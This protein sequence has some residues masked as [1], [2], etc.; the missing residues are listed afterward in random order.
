[1]KKPLPK[2]DEQREKR[3]GAV[4][5]FAGTPTSVDV[6]NRSFDIVV[7]TET[8]VRTWISDPRITG[9]D[10]DNVDC[11]SIEVD[12]VLVAAGLDMS[13]AFRMP[14]I[15]SHDTYSGIDKI[16]GKIDNL[17]VEGNQVVA[18]PTLTRARADLMPDIADGFYGQ[19]SAGYTPLVT[20]IVERE[21]QVPLAMV[22]KWVLTEASLVAVGADPNSFIRSA[23]PGPTPTV[24]YRA[25]PKTPTKETTMATKKTTNAA[26]KRADDG[27]A[28]GAPDIDAIVQQAEDAVAAAETAV[29]AVDDAVS[30]SSDVSDETMER[31][32][33]LRARL[34]AADD[35][36]MNGDDASGDNASG[37]TSDADAADQKAT[38][39]A[40]S[41][42]RSYGLTKL[43][44]DMVK[45]GARSDEVKRSLRTAI[46]AKTTTVTTPTA[47]ITQKE[48]AAGAKEEVS[49]FARQRTAFNKLNNANR[50]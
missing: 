7:T 2:P 39:E 27:T 8:P 38:D 31:A 47:S 19:I 43:V 26:R 34:R 5:A 33:G 41:I 23:G 11:S 24:T 15:D 9:N 6:A 3:A 32:R 28:A 42:A 44:D 14:L 48:R 46:S 20:E 13:R 17:R 18:T 22:T 1:M 25:L 29:S 37:D 10:L 35:E 40:R 4:R 21:G 36:D 16:I 50:K 12:E 49:D 30:N 45:L